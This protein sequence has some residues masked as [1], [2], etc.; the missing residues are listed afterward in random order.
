MNSQPVSGYSLEF[1]FRTT[2]NSGILA[3]GEG[4]TYF[5]LQLKDGRI[6]FDSSLSN[7]W[8]GIFAG[9][10]LNNGNWQRVLLLINETNVVLVGGQDTYVH[11]ITP[12]NNHTTFTTTTMGKACIPILLFQ[13]VQKTRSLSVTIYVV[14]IIFIMKSILYYICKN[15][16]E[17]SDRYSKVN[18]C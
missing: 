13:I 2:L 7:V 6:N 17:Q 10:S 16:V 12:E 15:N 5:I 4:Q 1:W 9:S 3:V 11:P 14:V 18:C 8:Q